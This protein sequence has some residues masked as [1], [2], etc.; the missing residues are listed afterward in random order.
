MVLNFM[1]CFVCIVILLLLYAV[2]ASAQSLV[3]GLVEISNQGAPSPFTSNSFTIT[4]ASCNQNPVSAATY[5]PTRLQFDD[6]TNVGKVCI[7]DQGPFLLALPVIPGNYTLT[8]TV[9]DDRG[10][11]SPRSAASNPFGRALPPIART[12]VRVIP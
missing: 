8:V 7:F 2:K 4:P 6:V 1:R 3:N 10:L 11:T 12:G 9:T 5:N